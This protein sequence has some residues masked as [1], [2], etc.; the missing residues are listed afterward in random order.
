MVEHPDI[1]T[2]PD[3]DLLLYDTAR[4]RPTR[5]WAFIGWLVI[6]G[7]IMLVL[8]N[9]HRWNLGVTLT[10][11]MVPLIGLIVGVLLVR[12][13]EGRRW[14]QRPLLHISSDRQWVTRYTPSGP[15]SH[16]V[17]SVTH[18]IFGMIDYPWPDRE[19]IAVEAFALYLAQQDG[20]PIPVVDGGEDKLRIFKLGQALSV[21]L[22][23]PLLQMG[24]GMSGESLR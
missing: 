11:L 1:K 5:D 16:A 8:N 18:V 20:T 12:G 19:G 3:G 9:V 17:G 14:R 15:E 7:M 2:L 10:E 21:I 23:R 6:G 24:K 4:I 13:G 22:G